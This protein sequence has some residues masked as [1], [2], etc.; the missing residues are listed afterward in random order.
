MTDDTHH[1]TDPANLEAEEQH[2]RQEVFL[3]DK[4]PELTTRAVIAGMLL[5]L[6]I[7]SENVYMGLK[8]GITEAGSILS[9]ILCFAVFRSL[10]KSCSILENNTAQTISSASGSIGIVVSVVPALQLVG[11]TLSG[12][13]IFIWVLLVACLGLLIAIPLR[14][15]L[16]AVEKL[17]FPTGTACAATITAMHARGE[18][19]LGK[20]K[21]LGMTGLISAVITWFRDAVPIVIP[22]TS[23]LPVGIGA[24]SLDQLSLGIYWSPL[25][26]GVGLLIG[27][28]V[29][30]S[31][32]LGAV[33][34]WGVLGPLLA[35]SRIIGSI[36][37][38]DVTHW[39]M[40]PAIALMVA[41]GFT[42]LA[43]KGGMISRTFRSMRAVS[44][45]RSNLIEFPFRLWWILLVV[46][47]IGL[48]FVMQVVLHVPIW[49][50]VIAVVLSFVF[51]SV[52]IRGYGETDINPVGPMGHA[53]QIVA[54]MA[55]PGSPVTNLAAG[56]VAAGCADVSAD[57]LQVLKTGHILGASPRRQVFAQFIGV[58]IGAVV[59]VLVYT[60][61]TRAY[62][63]GTEN[64]PAP[65]ALPWSGMATLLSKGAAA[66]PPFS[67]TA[68][69]VGGLLGIV[70]SLL[71][72]SGLGR[73]MPSPFGIGL[74]LVVP[75]FVSVSIF[76]G[77]LAGLLMEKRFPATAER[78]LVPIASGGIAG[79]AIMGVA[80]SI[81]AGIGLIAG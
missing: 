13:Q 75:G 40:W 39:T 68:V 64:L 55:S 57:L 73:Y 46:V 6:L 80:I 20:A 56:G 29:G 16:I 67:L 71:E 70:L 72:K 19:A 48:L 12:F 7:M 18:D 76:L 3:G 9:A 49:L 69:V 61:V 36:G 74:G 77:S 58:G 23:T 27:V 35:D 41:S 30:A 50:G 45:D 42:S 53:N 51:S 15:Q 59:S 5:G 38:T 33:A 34:G 11:Y 63:I 2:W 32:L 21:A 14:R 44:Y 22:T 24:Y 62:G 43:L 28:R 54:G 66:L 78:Y 8:T 52:A 65:G 4:V 60:V 17:T 26:L 79:E 31:L 37:H 1:L 47:I 10:G 81:L 25:V